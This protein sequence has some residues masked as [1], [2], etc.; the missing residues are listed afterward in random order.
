MSCTKIINLLIFVQ[1]A[2]EKF[3]Q[4]HKR[5]M[6]EFSADVIAEEAVKLAA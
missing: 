5:N 2:L 4:I 6:A 3:G 1:Y